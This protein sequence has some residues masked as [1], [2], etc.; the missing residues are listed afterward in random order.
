MRS[1]IAASGRILVLTTRGASGSTGFAQSSAGTDTSTGPRG[2][3]I[4]V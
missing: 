3:C 1:S 2:S 4:A